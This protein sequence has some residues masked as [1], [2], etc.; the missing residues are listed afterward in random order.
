LSTKEKHNKRRSDDRTKRTPEQ[1]PPRLSLECRP[2]Q[3]LQS[4]TAMGLT[5]SRNE[6]S[7]SIARPSSVSPSVVLKQKEALFISRFI[8]CRRLPHINPPL[9]GVLCSAPLCHR[10]RSCLCLPS[11]K[12]EAL[13]L[14]S[15]HFCRRR[16]PLHLITPAAIRCLQHY[17]APQP[18]C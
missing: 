15:L 17:D 11:L 13:D 14:A 10:R 7:K 3:P 1:V 16:P 12:N 8:F 9:L 6:G 18:S 2:Y 5:G 4:G